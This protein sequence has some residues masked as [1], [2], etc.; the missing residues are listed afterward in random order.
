[1]AAQTCAAGSTTIGICPEF[2][3]EPAPTDRSQAA[4]LIHEA[5][6][7][8]FHFRHH[9]TANVR[10]RGRNPGCYQGFVLEVFNTGLTPGDC[11]PI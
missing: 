1:M 5:I 7:P 3:N 2:W 10:V 11:T 8:L 4:V 6:H 9:G